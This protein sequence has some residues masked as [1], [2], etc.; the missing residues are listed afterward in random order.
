MF[1]KIIVVGCGRLGADLAFRLFKQG[2]EVVVIDNLAAAF[3]N[4]PSEFSGRTVEGDVLNREV[5]HRAGI[6]KADALAAVT[7]T[8]TINVVVARIAKAVYGL[9]N[10][11]VRNYDPHFSD[12]LEAF[13]VQFVS[14]TIWGAKRM[15]E[16]INH[17]D[18]RAVFST[19]NGEVEV[20]ELVVPKAW[21]D[22]PLSELAIKGESM[23]ISVTRAGKALLP[24]EGMLMLDCDVVNI[25]ATGTGIAIL[26]Q[27]LTA[28]LEA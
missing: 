6:E 5:L 3:R 14:S 1:M 19:G 9:T 10:I 8:D 11:V 12:L 15:E 21:G 22:H 20:Y 28:A 25:S 4:L 24:F 7:N 17:T 27:R 26:R 23:V 13:G 2:H 18:V 16:L